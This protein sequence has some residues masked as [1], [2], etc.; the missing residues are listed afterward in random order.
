MCRFNPS[1]LFPTVLCFNQKVYN[2][3][4]IYPE[5]YDILGVEIGWQ[6]SLLRQ[7]DE[8]IAATIVC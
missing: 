4:H 7:L 1:A 8:R 2:I 3:Y 6:G 5:I